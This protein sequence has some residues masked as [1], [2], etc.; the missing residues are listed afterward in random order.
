M[1]PSPT[2]N[3][4]LLGG[5]MKDRIYEL[6]RLVKNDGLVKNAT[7]YFVSCCLKMLPKPMCIIS[8]ADSGQ[9]HHGYIYQATNFIYCGLTNKMF[10]WVGED[11]KHNRHN[12]QRNENDKKV[13]RSRKHR[14]VYF[15]GNKTQIKEM[16]YNLSYPIED[17]PKG[18]NQRYD[19]SYNPVI[20]SQ[21]F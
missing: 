21:L 18:N 20:Q 17:Y 10:D 2:V 1:P 8:Y 3:E 15:L 4:G 5:F 13:E 19:A 7:S 12:W 11:N 14:Y 16:K 9:G 6:N